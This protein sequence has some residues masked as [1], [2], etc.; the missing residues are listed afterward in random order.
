MA[1]TVT[2]HSGDVYTFTGRN[3]SKEFY[4][5]HELSKNERKW[6][7]KA[8]YTVQVGGMIYRFNKD[9]S[10]P[11][12]NYNIFPKEEILKLVQFMRGG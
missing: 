5:I 8:D 7:E 12:T 9:G 4:T 10:T 6:S 3:V 1:K 11:K 2:T